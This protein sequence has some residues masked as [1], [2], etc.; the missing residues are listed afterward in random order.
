MNL[1]KVQISKLSAFDIIIEGH[2][3]SMFVVEGMEGRP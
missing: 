2:L 1:I 3:Q